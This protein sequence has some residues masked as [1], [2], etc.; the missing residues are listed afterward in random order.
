M[1]IYQQSIYISYMWPFYPLYQFYRIEVLSE[2]INNLK[3]NL[4]LKQGQVG[5]VFWENL[6]LETMYPKKFHKGHII[7]SPPSSLRNDGRDCF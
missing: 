7:I 1:F 2:H 6:P 4:R 5:Y 3:I